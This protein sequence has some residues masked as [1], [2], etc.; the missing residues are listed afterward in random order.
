M[1]TTGI[2][3]LFYT[4]GFL[5]ASHP[6][7]ILLLCITGTVCLL[8]LN[9]YDATHAQDSL[10]SAVTKQNKN[11]FPVSIHVQISATS[12]F[13]A[14]LCVYLQC[15]KILHTGS[16]Y[17]AVIVGIFLIF[18]CALY[19]SIIGNI[20]RGELSILREAIPFFFLLSDFVTVTDLTKFALLSTSCEEATSKIAQGVATLSPSV[21]LNTLVGALVIGVGSLSGIQELETASYLGCLALVTHY[22]IF[23]TFL[24]ASLSLFLELCNRGQNQPAWLLDSSIDLDVEEHQQKSNPLL[25]HVKII[26]SA[27]LLYVHMYSRLI[28]ST[29]S[30][31]NT[32]Y[33]TSGSPTASSISRFLAGNAEEV[34]AFVLALLVAAK[35][36]YLE[37]NESRVLI[38]TTSEV[39]SSYNV[40]EAKKDRLVIGLKQKKRIRRATYTCGDDDSIDEE[41]TEMLD[42][43]TQTSEQCLVTKTLKATLEDTMEDTMDTKKSPKNQSFSFTHHIPKWKRCHSFNDSLRVTVNDNPPRCVT[44]LEKSNNSKDN[45]NFNIPSVIVSEH[46]DLFEKPVMSGCIESAGS[47]RRTCRDGVRTVGECKKIMKEPDGIFDLTDEEI[48]SLVDEKVIPFYQLESALN[49]FQ[50][51]VHIRRKITS[52]KINEDQDTLSGLPYQHYDYKLV[53]GACCENVIGYM[54]IPVGVAG[55]LH[56]DGKTYYVP[57]A[58]TEGCLVASTNR[59]CRALAGSGGVR[60]SVIGDGMTRGPVVR[61]P[62]AMQASEVKLWLEDQLNFAAIKKSFDSTSRFARL[63]SI[64]CA[65]AGRLL[66][67]RFVATTGDAMGMNM[68][69]KGTEKALKELQDQFPS[70]EILSLS[71]NYCTDKKATAINWIEG[72]GKSVVCEAIVPAHV[73]TKVL[74]TSV[75]ALTELNTSKNLVGSAMAGAIGGFNAHA[76][77]IVT[78]LFIAT[79]QDP[80]QNLASSNCI[81]LLEPCGPNHQDLYIS[82]TMPSL[83][84]GTVGGGTILAPQTS[85]LQMLGVQGACNE[86]PGQNATQLSRI[87]CA[88]VLAGELSLLSALAAGQLVQSHLKHNRSTINLF[89]RE[90]PMKNCAVL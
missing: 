17:L 49:N 48:C 14:L 85:C 1:K 54:P 64:K 37:K 36:L 11:H 79:G 75:S 52:H 2:T 73:V 43:N 70:M 45:L 28:V 42:E 78:A 81:T 56:L 53:S 41:I 39:S 40:K 13:L 25:Q 19:T 69:S 77:N 26:M 60:S 68:L 51:A 72:R 30:E 15:K 12:Y 74:K 24:P 84:V 66:F 18:S 21:T 34:V 89:G 90:E 10:V 67:A 86:E 65:V 58:T 33:K 32:N 3:S 4:H 8:T 57:M 20:F 46:Q 87:I 44:A 88:T 29:D 61:F 35:Y 59:G 83:E 47:E 27:G 76:A 6:V 5:C 82:C 62:S 80:A 63:K 16:T 71:G 50:R 23:M 22:I 38:D 9:I 7:E 55:P 31:N